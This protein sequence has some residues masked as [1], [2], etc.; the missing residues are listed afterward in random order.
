[1][2]LFIVVKHTSL[3]A[4]VLITLWLI[5][6][7]SRLVTTKDNKS[8]KQKNEQRKKEYNRN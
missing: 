2:F 4:C 3:L 5:A 6:F 1:M 8:L 7:V